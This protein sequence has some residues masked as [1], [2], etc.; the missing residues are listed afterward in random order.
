MAARRVLML[1]TPTAARQ[2]TSNSIHQIVLHL[3]QHL[4][5]AG[6]VLT[7][8]PDNADIIAGHAGQTY[9][10]ERVHVAHCH[11]LYPTTEARTSGW[12]WGANAAVIRNLRDALAITAPSQWVADIIRRDMCVEPDVIGWA[13][14]NGAWR[15]PPKRES[16][17]LW[18]KNRDDGVCDPTPVMELAR[19]VPE[20]EFVS[21]FGDSLSNLRITGRM[22]FDAM[23]PLI[24]HA[25]LYLATTK[26]TF[27]IGTLE[28]M[29]CGVPVL[30]YRWGGTA[31]LVEHGVTGYLVTPGDID[32]LV[33][34]WHY[35]MQHRRTLGYNARRVAVQYTWDRV[36]DRFAEVYN[37]VYD[38]LHN[39]NPV[40]VSVVIPAYNYLRYLPDA[41]ESA[42]NQQ[43]AFP[44]EV[45]VVNDNSTD[46]TRE[47]LEQ[48]QAQ[49]VPD[50]VT[51]RVIHH[52]QNKRVAETRNHGIREARGEYITCLD[53]DDRLGAPDFL[54]R[55]AAAMDADN[56]LGVAFTGL[57]V[58][59]PEH[60]SVIP[61]PW[62]DGYD[63][64]KQI[65]RN[66][67][68]PT[69]NMFRKEAWRRAGGYRYYLEP[70]EDAELWL[71]MGSLGYT[72]KQV[73]RE[74]IFYYRVHE[75]SLSHS[76]RS[77]Q[78]PEPNWRKF[79][80]WVRDNLRPFA[81]DGRPRQHSWPVRNYDT[82]AV[83]VVIPVGPGHA[84]HLRRALDSVNGQTR[85]D[86]E[87]I[88][89]N[90]SGET[91]E[92][93]GYPW[94]K[95]CTSGGARNAG[96]ARNIGIQEASAP[97]VAFLDADD[98]LEPTFLQ[99]TLNAHQM[100]GRYVYTDWVSRNTRGDYETH[101]T[102]EY[103]TRR[104]FVQTSI[105]AV[106]ILIPR[107]WLN[108][109]GGFAE[110]MPAWEDVDLMMK[111]AKHGYCGK[112][113]AK[114]LIVYDYTTGY[115]REMSMSIKEQL[116]AVLQSRYG[117]FMGENAMACGCKK[118]KA[119]LAPVAE[120]T[121][122]MIRIL[123]EGPPAAHSVVGA[124]THKNYGRRR[125]GDTFFVYAEDVKA[126][127]DKFIPLSAAAALEPTPQP[128]TPAR[129]AL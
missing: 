69:C 92:L 91:L 117:E 35:C 10:K 125:G 127:P 121:E 90:D 100:T 51:L 128:D 4:P 77:A 88:V 99:E 44:F 93:T 18:N 82:P 3:E 43:T 78:K 95:L 54:Q 29:A 36:A 124:T 74:P 105:H 20:G 41:L 25:A 106:N 109:V 101:E 46:G 59:H 37:R 87:C 89:V 75:A 67:Q 65:S 17:T 114:P 107:Q 22:P 50:N 120:Q 49:P 84:Q 53:A 28:A 15:K 62:P 102:P 61:Q 26:E 71:R 79:H 98:M 14:E 68:I 58:M 63:F 129:V 11:G 19:R 47:Y 112:R 16:Y 13:I 55:L 27:G 31:Q 104:V 9:S 39:T 32:G 115:L 86:W 103:D 24:Q 81:S 72:A 108:D 70:A 94:V 123:Y 60:N 80:P 23:K 45:I 119:K 34:G 113:V 111:L 97:L 83:S 12:H 8:N 116:I 42:L 73:T 21:T 57:G 40:K 52:T 38:A 56:Q 33:E 48:R 126:Q 5:M 1:P 30:G 76:V 96:R 85:R 2:D 118:L 66:N 6:W 122:G 64:E 110:D 7:E